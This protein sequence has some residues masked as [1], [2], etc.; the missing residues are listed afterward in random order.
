M[1]KIDLHIHT[2][3]SGHAYST[4]LESARYANSV[5]VEVI[6][7]TDHGPSMD[8]SSLPGYFGNMGRIPRKMCG[9]NILMGC[10]ANVIDLSGKVDLGVDII[11]G[12]DIILVGLHKFTPYPS[13]SSLSDNTNA[14]I[15]AI[16]NHKV[17]V[18]SHPYRP[19]FPVDIIELVRAASGQG[20]VLEL[21]LSLLK[22]FSNDKELL[23][24]INLMIEA[25]EKMRVKI[26]VSSDA[27]IA[28]EIGDDSVLSDLHI[29]IPKGLL[30][31]GQD[32][33][34]EIKEFLTSRGRIK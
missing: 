30:L 7:I 22:L 17:H 15:S 20:V 28:T 23:K 13:N 19:D 3:A 9:V 24:Q 18:V 1:L 14:L 32:G 5:G 31:G 11:D 16:T 10:E 34:N 4:I 6:A 33:Y 2:V 25:A 27:H 8:G 26:A 29:Q 12:L 21:N